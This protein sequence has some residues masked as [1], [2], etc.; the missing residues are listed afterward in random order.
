MSQVKLEVS[1]IQSS[2]AP[3]LEKYEQIAGAYLV[4]SA[5]ELC[6]PDSDIDIGLVLM[7]STK[8]SEKELDLI[9]ARILEELSPQAA[10]HYD[11][12]FLTRGNAFLSHRALKTGKLIYARDMDVITDFTEEISL[13]YRVDYPRYRKA[14]ETIAGG[15]DFNDN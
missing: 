8:I 1:Q 11:L 2:I 14:L 3:V 15:D 12:V 10:H 9:E 4:G 13:K 7:H 6:R 5:L